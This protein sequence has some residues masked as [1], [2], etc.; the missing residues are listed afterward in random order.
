[1][2][3]IVRILTR[4]STQLVNELVNRQTRGGGGSQLGAVG[5]V[6]TLGGVEKITALMDFRVASFSSRLLL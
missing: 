2:L 5:D 4:K 6:Y 3:K 1:M